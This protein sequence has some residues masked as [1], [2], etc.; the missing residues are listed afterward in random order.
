MAIDEAILRS[1]INGE[2]P[3]T[4]RFYRWNP[5]AVSLGYFQDPYK[6][7]NLEYCKNNGIDVVR[8]ITGGYA[9]LHDNEL[10]YSIISSVKNRIFRGSIIRSYELIS[11]CIADALGRLGIKTEL[12]KKPSS[13]AISGDCFSNP[14]KYE[15]LFKG[16]KIVGS[17]QKRFKEYFLQHGSIILSMNG[18]V[19]SSI[20][21]YRAGS[22]SLNIDY[23]ALS[24]E[25]RISIRRILGVDLKEGRLSLE[26]ERLKD[27]LLREKYLKEEWN[28]RGKI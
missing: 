14:S 11:L 1:C 17:A 2:S 20:F 15:I 26:E 24:R 18:D 6:D 5:K 27:L 28:L 3:P 12:V 7:L 25:L 21:N 8:R 16:R 9:V 10:T 4:I 22:I 23:E 19:L 13:S